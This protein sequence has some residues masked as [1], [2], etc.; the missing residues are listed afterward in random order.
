VKERVPGLAPV[1]VEW[2]LNQLWHC[3]SS[4]RE[5]PGSNCATLLEV[6][7]RDN[8]VSFEE[9]APAVDDLCAMPLWRFY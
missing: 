3:A 2:F 7:G 6:G 4:W 9:M 8:C 1:D 5:V